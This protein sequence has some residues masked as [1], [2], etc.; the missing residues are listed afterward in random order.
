M[1][2][3]HLPM[4]YGQLLHR[5]FLLSKV[6]EDTNFQPAKDKSETLSVLAHLLVGTLGQKAKNNSNLQGARCLYRIVLTR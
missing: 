6:N 2:Q 4:S 3:S 5:D 1:F